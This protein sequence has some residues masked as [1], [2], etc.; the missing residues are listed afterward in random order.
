VCVVELLWSLSPQ[1]VII[2]NSANYIALQTARAVNGRKC[3]FYLAFSL[4]DYPQ[5]EDIVSQARSSG[6]T[7]G[8]EENTS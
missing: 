6:E 7:E 3:E 4:G 2:S 5:V 1:V 8:A